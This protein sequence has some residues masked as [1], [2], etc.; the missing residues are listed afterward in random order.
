MIIQKAKD[1]FF[2]RK[3]WPWILLLALLVALVTLALILFPLPTPVHLTPAETAWMGSHSIRLAPNPDFPPVEYFDAN[4][5]YSGMIADYYK[6]I[7]RNLNIRI[8]FT[9]FNSWAEVQQALENKQIDGIT[10]G[11]INDSS[12][13]G[14]LYTTPLAD[15]PIVIITSTNWAGELRL[16]DM[17]GWSMAITDG[18][19]YIDYIKSNNPYITV[20]PAVNDLEALRMVS[21]GRVD[22]ALVNQAVASYLIEN[23]GIPNL[24][25]SGDLKQ[26]NSLATAIRRDE[27][28]LQSILQKGLA[29]ISD[30][31]KT[32]ISHKWLGLSGQNLFGNSQFWLIAFWA[33]FIVTILFAF[34]LTWN[35]TLQTQVATKTEQLNRE[36]ME[37]RDAEQ[38]LSQQLD[39]L[40]AL[41]AVGVAINASMDLPL[42]LK[43]LLDQ[44]SSKL[45]VDACNI[46]LF[47]P[48]TRS[49]EQAAEKGFRT[50]FTIM[51]TLDSSSANFAWQAVKTRQSVFENLSENPGGF[52][53]TPGFENEHFVSYICTPLLAKGMVKGV[54]EIFNRSTLSS[55]S[56]WMDFLEAMTSQAA[57]ALDN[58]T[59][60]Q[61]LQ[62]AN[63]EITLAYDATIEGW[64]KALELRDGTTEGHSKRVMQ[65][66]MDLAARMGFK[67]EE[68]IHIRRGALLH[69]I[70]KMGI[71]DNIL[72]KPGPLTPEEWD[73]M[74]MH[75]TY[76]RDMLKNVSYLSQALD[77]PY[78]HHEKWDGTGYPQSL[79]GDRI[80]LAA[81]L[82]AIIDV[83]DALTS[84]RPYRKAWTEDTTLKYIQDNSGIHFD[85]DVVD[86]FIKMIK[87]S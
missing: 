76:A 71:P 54:L 78:S 28:E 79:H 31:Q 68:L 15:I 80:P 12:S 77:I 39:N 33:L 27:P 22:T 3:F 72:Q 63:L 49:L 37:K 66:T 35:H 52:A 36:L 55:K 26:S 60:F 9:R 4:G 41:R 30:R 86:E 67:N 2:Q 32:E 51:R 5:E 16:Q 74:K 14:M 13:S 7:S 73:I 62:R 43:V 58:A 64:A 6:L 20:V 87:M 18:Y 8:E 57:I 23:N 25:I 83:W 44:V 38:R 1:F 65:M 47:N 34:S 21:A 75:P 85:P 84:D 69:D 45:N 82:F 53:N 17:D 50:Q 11:P 46:L 59:L 10:A 48:H 19:P 56:E 81:R 29:S 61:G 40:S 24:R 42:T 70:G